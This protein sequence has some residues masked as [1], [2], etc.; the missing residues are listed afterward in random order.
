MSMTP[1][2]SGDTLS[3]GRHGLALFVSVVLSVVLH[4]VAV[5]WLREA[6]LQNVADRMDAVR[7][8]YVTPENLP[9]VHIGKLIHAT[10]LERPAVRAEA[11]A[12]PDASADAEALPDHL[13][14]RAEQAT[15]D[16]PEVPVV[17]AAEIPSGGLVPDD[18][19]APE[20]PLPEALIPK[21]SVRQAVV[22][23]PDTEFTRVTNPDP[24]WTIDDRIV[25]V[26]D[27]PDLASSS[28][29]E[30]DGGLSALA[31]PP[32]LPVMGSGAGLDFL[33]AQGGRAAADA[34]V[35]SALDVAASSLVAEA[36]AA[37]PPPEAVAAVPP[38][39]D[40]GRGYQPIDDR[41]SVKL[42]T[43]ETREDAG[44]VY[45]R[46][47][48]KRRPEG[49]L[50]ILAKDVVFIQDI[51]GSIG[52]R[53]LAACKEA[54]K[55]ALFNTLRAGD[56]FNIFAFRD[57]T[58]APSG[59]WLTFDP[60]TRVKAETFVDSLR[61]IGNTD[62][63]LLLQDLRTLPSDPKRP[64]IAVVVTDGEPTVGMT[65]TA[66]I[67]GEFTRIN[68]GNIAVYTFGVK[69]RNPYFLDMLTYANR[70]EN[71]ATAGNINHLAEEL[72]PVF[73]SIRNPVL[74]NPTLIF[75]AASGSEV[76]PRHLTH[77]YADRPMVLYGRVPRTTRRVTCQL[78]GEAAASPYDAVFSFDL[79]T[80]ARTEDNLRRAWAERAMFDL[81]SDYASNP[82]QELLRRIAA[83]SH[84][85]NVPNP[86]AV[87]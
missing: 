11:D 86:Y 7:Q 87:R 39:A 83:F 57:V 24:K 27:A 46:L 13:A 36:L 65:E 78:R 14:E 67:I 22:A 23:V 84:Q 38:P 63:F 55:S 35:P 42:E 32:V 81:L 74:K 3:F 49:A 59:G 45:Y 69:K 41:L 76:H 70:G 33:V 53:R 50:P 58:L 21:V 2:E 20:A 66:R 48:V 17:E 31:M 40:A 85:Y 26:P 52:G 68:Q 56:R 79:G 25:R 47:T 29:G 77:L 43:F 34:A 10:D 1:A 30:E 18:V 75:G 8:A 44:H 28:L 71:T 62:L 60:D 6:R 73:E 72:V 54:M 12:A 51:S 64:L 5:Y 16:M 61:A 37:V 15:P 9:P 82:S 80:A 4:F 19:E